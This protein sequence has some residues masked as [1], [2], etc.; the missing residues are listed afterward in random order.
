MDLERGIRDRSAD[1][2]SLFRS[3]FTNSEGAAEGDAVG[4]LMATLLRTPDADDLKVYSGW[5]D[6][7][8]VAC[9][10][11]SRM[12]YSE[13]PRVVFLLSPVAVSTP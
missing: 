8:P 5:I 1:I 7:A 13:D 9:I 11:F 10:A 2:V 12:V 3:T 6:D 4:N